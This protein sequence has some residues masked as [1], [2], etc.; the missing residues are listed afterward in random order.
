MTILG[1]FIL[2]AMGTVVPGYKITQQA[3]ESVYAQKEII[4]AFD[5]L[6]AEMTPLDRASVTTN[7][8]A[9]SFLSD[10]PFDRAGPPIA[11]PNLL[12]LAFS[13]PDRIWL[14][15]VILHHRDGHLWRR[16]YSYLK[17]S[18]LFAIHPDNLVAVS[19]ASGIPE[20]IFVKN[21]ELFE[22]ESC[23]RNRI[24]LK[25]RSVFRKANRPTAAEIN[26]QISM[27]GGN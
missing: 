16:E 15:H 4:L 20:K 25:V 22:A 7:A 26:L 13:S 23:G 12:D 19:G 8:N 18:E 5:R 10:Q 21:I 1:S 27:R 9:L 17:G 14:K 2:L 6:V 24:R 11:D 3:E